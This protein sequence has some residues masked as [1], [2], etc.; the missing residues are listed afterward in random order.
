MGLHLS[1]PRVKICW[2]LAKTFITSILSAFSWE[3][4]DIPT[5]V[6]LT[7]NFCGHTMVIHGCLINFT[8][9][10]TVYSLG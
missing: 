4:L 3:S 5:N 10:C 6:V 9:Y 8:F 2:N 1:A 7:V